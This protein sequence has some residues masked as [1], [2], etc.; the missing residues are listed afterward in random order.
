MPAETR[1]ASVCSGQGGYTIGQN[2]EVCRSSGEWV[3]GQI[4]ALDAKGKVTV[5]IA[6]GLQKHIQL[7]QEA[8]FLRPSRSRSGFTASRQHNT[9][10]QASSH[11]IGQNVWVLRSSG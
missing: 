2:V 10:A 6:N 8:G 7:P 9:T 11:T 3:Q 1:P 5:N 4:F